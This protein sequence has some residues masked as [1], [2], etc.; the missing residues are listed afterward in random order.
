M[1][2]E[3]NWALVGLVGLSSQPLAP[4][5]RRKNSVSSSPRGKRVVLVTLHRR[6]G[7]YHLRRPGL[8]ASRRA[9]P[10]SG[11]AVRRR[12]GKQQNPFPNP[13]LLMY[14][15]PKDKRGRISG[16]NSLLRAFPLLPQGAF[17]AIW[18]AKLLRRRKVNVLKVTSVAFLTSRET[19]ARG[20]R[21]P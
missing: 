15:A 5:W 17:S 20:A 13:R 11:A 12:R 18:K 6:F 19:R 2:E 1:A 21:Q 4:W 3:T 9:F 7:E 8:A 16:G 14:G 10:G